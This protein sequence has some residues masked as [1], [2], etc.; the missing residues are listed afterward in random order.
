MDDDSGDAKWFRR[1][2]KIGLIAGGVVGIIAGIIYGYIFGFRD[3]EWLIAAEVMCGCVLVGLAGG[4]AVGAVVGRVFDEGKVNGFLKGLIG[5]SIAGRLKVGGVVGGIA[6][7]V[8]GWL[9]IGYF[10][11]IASGFKSCF[12]NWFRWLIK[13]LFHLFYGYEF[14]YTASIFGSAML[15]GAT[16]GCLASVV[17][18]R[19]KNERRGVFLCTAGGV[20][21][22]IGGLTIIYFWRFW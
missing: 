15:G 18:G 17:A 2:V 19:V 5:G 6:G 14:I 9:V 8:V 3:D 13:T 7:F 20:V 4:C 1:T 10:M 21:G 11:C 22:A 16:G 12:E